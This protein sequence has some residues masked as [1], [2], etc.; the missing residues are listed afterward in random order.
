ML[1]EIL[2]ERHAAEH[3][4]I[5]KV[6]SS[7]FYRSGSGIHCQIGNTA[8]MANPIRTLRHAAG[9]SQERLATLAETST[10]QIARLENGQRKLTREWAER[11]A[12]PLNTTW[13]VVIGATGGGLS[14]SVPAF[15]A[16]APPSEWERLPEVSA[17]LAA[18]L[19]Q[20]GVPLAPQRL[21]ALAQKTLRDISALGRALP[22]EERLAIAVSEVRSKQLEILE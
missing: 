15:A 21:T 5:G 17:A 11:L 10:A 2:L 14:E 1:R 6:A 20:I 7:P 12:G 8:A 22:F 9:L 13:Q 16:P 3:H 19:A 4:Q 18:M